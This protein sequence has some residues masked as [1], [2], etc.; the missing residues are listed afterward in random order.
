MNIFISCA[1]FY[2]SKL[3]GPAN[4]LY[5]LAKGLVSKGHNVYVVSTHDF[6][7]DVKI[8]KNQKTVVDGINVFYAINRVKLIQK[9]IGLIRTCDSVILSSVCYS[10]ELLL[11]LFAKSLHKKVIWSP[12]GEFTQSAIGGKKTKLAFFELIKFLVGKYVVF[13]ATSKDEEECIRRILG[14]GVN[15][16]IIPNYMEIPEKLERQESDPPYILFLGRIAPIKAIENLIKGVSISSMFRKSSVELKIAGG[17]ENQFR[18]Y[19]Q[20]LLNLI[21]SEGLQEKVKFIGPVSG[22]QKYHT[23]C[24]AKFLFLVSNSENFGNVVIEA[25]SQGTPVVASL[26]TPWKGLEDFHAGFWIS[27][28]PD[29]IGKIIDKILSLSE[30]QYNKYRIAA[31]SYANTFNIY[32]NTEC[33]EN[34]IK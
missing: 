7:E 20:S 12:R 24:D 25:L 26:G 33:W 22:E 3:G 9:S 19:H 10:P 23:Y 4:T 28:S 17:I 21:E 6:I 14:E 15:T 27:N 5:W 30:E 32:S 29:E 34:V 11:A 31:F 13:H 16:T 2:P 18:A 8:P 1:L